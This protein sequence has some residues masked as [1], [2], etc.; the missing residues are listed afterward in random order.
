MHCKVVVGRSHYVHI[1]A[2]WSAPVWRGR[3]FNRVHSSPK[4]PCVPP[5][6]PPNPPCTPSSAPPL[7]HPP[8]LQCALKRLPILSI[9]WKRLLPHVCVMGGKEKVRIPKENVCRFSCFSVSTFQARKVQSRWKQASFENAPRQDPWPKVVQ[10]SPRTLWK[11]GQ[12]PSP[13]KERST[14]QDPKIPLDS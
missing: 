6:C 5:S 7:H 1:A 8:Q 13:H 10:I 2:P 14:L 11:S 4:A 12:C 3:G 9:S